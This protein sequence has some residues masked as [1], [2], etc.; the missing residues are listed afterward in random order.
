MEVEKTI[1]A[2]LLA[3]FESTKNYFKL[4]FGIKM[5]FELL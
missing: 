1:P 3:D 5:N 4:F 2:S